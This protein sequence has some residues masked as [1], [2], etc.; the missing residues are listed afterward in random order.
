MSAED[1]Q[2]LLPKLTDGQL[3]TLKLYGA[4]ETTSVGQVLAAA[5]DLT[6]DLMVVLDG[7][8]EISDIHDGRRRALV[9]FGPRDFIAEL[10]LLTGQRVYVTVVVTEAGSI[11]RVPRSAVM[12]II[13]P[14]GRSANDWCRRSSA[15]ARRSSFSAPVCS[16]SDR[17]T[18]LT[19][20]ARA[21]SPPVTAF[22]FRG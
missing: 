7:E 17:A 14:T 13:E 15:D 4:T 1:G 8:V 21:S 9:T 22:S 19:P 12:A 2:Q 3:A 18:H 11:T 10:N 5:G 6:Y 20:S 16:S